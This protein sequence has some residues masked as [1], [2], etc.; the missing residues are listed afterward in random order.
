MGIFKIPLTPVPQSFSIVLGGVHYALNLHWSAAEQM[1]FWVVDIADA[2]TREPIITGIPLVTG[3][4]LLAQFEYLGFNG[5]LIAYVS[6]SDECPG[7]DNLGGAG[8]LFFVTEDD[9]D[10]AA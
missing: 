4:D 10:G 3:C 8:N 6:G 1:Q 2:E 7:F 9:A 5:K